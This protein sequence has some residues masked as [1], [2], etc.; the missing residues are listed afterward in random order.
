MA[1]RSSIRI[2]FRKDCWQVEGEDGD[3]GKG[4]E[5][6]RD[7]T[8]Q[9]SFDCCLAGPAAACIFF[10]P[11]LPFSPL[12]TPLLAPTLIQMHDSTRAASLF[13]RSL[14]AHRFTDHLAFYA[15]VK[16]MLSNLLL[17]CLLSNSSSTAILLL[18]S[19]V[20]DGKNGSKRKV[21]RF[22]RLQSLAK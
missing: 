16:M 18:Q 10:S 4:R 19:I 14:R 9:A 21:H 8:Q 20:F 13:I 3:E 1:L 6:G 11:S 2:M 7:K 22:V 12:G 5:E 17:L 15:C